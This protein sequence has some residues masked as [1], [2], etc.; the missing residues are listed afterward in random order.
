MAEIY[1]K[2]NYLMTD[3]DCYDIQLL[4]MADRDPQST[5]AYLM[6]DY[7]YLY[8]GEKTQYELDRS[9]GLKPGI[10]K[11]VDKNNEI[12]RVDPI[13]DEEKVK[14]RF[15]D[16]IGSVKPNNIVDAINKDKSIIVQLPEYNKISF[17]N[18]SK[19]DD[20]FKRLIKTAFN[21]KGIGVD[22]CESGFADKNARFNF[23]QAV[24]GSNRLSIMYFDRGCEAL[25]IGYRI[26]LYDKN[27]N[28]PVGA[29]LTEPIVMGTDDSFD[30]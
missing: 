27:P 3:D 9:P 24:T 1:G 23:K 29:P 4:N 28:N 15:E 10:Y 26:E 2:D 16:K 18:I 7:Y 30:L 25:G 5:V 11:I 8:R 17:S 20:L 14:Y 21:K 22:D 6:G 12:Y 19:D 13:T